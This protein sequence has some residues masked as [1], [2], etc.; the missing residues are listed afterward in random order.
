MGSIPEERLRLVIEDEAAANELCTQEP[1]HCT[2]LL[3]DPAGVLGDK[4]R[5]PDHVCFESFLRQST[6]LWSDSYL[7][8]RSI[9]RRPGASSLFVSGD[10]WR[11]WWPLPVGVSAIS[12]ADLEAAL[13]RGITSKRPA[14]GRRPELANL[15]PFGGDEEAL[16]AL[17]VNKDKTTLDL[18]AL[19]DYPGG[20]DRDSII[21][22]GEVLYTLRGS[23][24][25]LID[26][27]YAAKRWWSGFRGTK[28]DG[29]PK[30]SGIW[31]SADNYETALRRAISTLRERRDKVTQ[32][33]V[34]GLLGCD[35]SQ[36]RDWNK[37]FGISWAQI[38]KL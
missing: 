35:D 2:D 24:T 34:A 16:W 26:L 18:F 33:A 13:A 8:G 21:K 22:A 4:Q 23:D 20:R 17:R 31:A 27:V 3:N 1:P 10:V 9:T 32:E 12:K 11:G 5:W 6:E 37:R 19:A 38:K 36:I 30:N 7:S 15:V 28:I 29:R 25:S 14:G